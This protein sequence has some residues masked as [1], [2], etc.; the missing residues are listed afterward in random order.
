MQKILGI[1]TEARLSNHS[2]KSH[3]KERSKPPLAVGWIA[4]EIV[5]VVLFFIVLFFRSGLKK[6]PDSKTVDRLQ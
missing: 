5:L 2:P 1:F 3:A 4:S 6:Q